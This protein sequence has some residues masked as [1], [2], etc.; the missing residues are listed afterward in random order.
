MKDVDFKGRLAEHLN[1]QSGIVP[2][3]LDNVD[4]LFHNDLCISNI[5]RW[6]DGREQRDI[7]SEGLCGHCPT[8]SDS[9][10]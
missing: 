6:I 4:A 1:D 2:C 9:A 10:K 7:H 8:P 5:V 3:G